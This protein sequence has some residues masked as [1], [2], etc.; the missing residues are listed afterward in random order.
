MNASGAL[1]ITT[2]SSSNLSLNSNA[3]LTS[4]ATGN[5]ISLIS[6]GNLTLESG[7][8]ISAAGPVL[9]AGN[10][11][12]NNAGS[13]AVTAS[14][15][16]WLIYSNNPG[17]D[18][19]G[20]LNSGNNA[21]WDASYGALPPGNVTAGSNRYLFA[22]QPTLTFTTTGASKTY[23]Q[24]VTSSIANNFS[25]SGY[26]S[27]I[28]N[29][30][31][32]DAAGSTFSGIP[33]VT[34]NGA[35]ASASV[36]GS[37]YAISIAQ[38]TVAALSGY[39]LTFNSA[40][41]L[42]VNPAQVTV[43]ALGGSSTYGASPSNPGLSAT[44]LQNGQGV[45]VLT[46][47]SNSF[48]IT[49]TSNAGNYTLNVAGTLSDANYTVA[50]AN[51]G[52]WTVDPAQVIVTALG[53]S[54]T[55]GAPSSNPGLS[56]TGMQNG[57][58]VGVLD[59]AVELVRN[60]CDVARR[61]SLTERHRYTQQFELRSGRNKKRSLERYCG[62]YPAFSVSTSLALLAYRSELLAEYFGAK[63]L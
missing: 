10:A 23:G 8:S 47:L 41:T 21:I 35:V 29:V 46:G 24:D 58:N 42:A 33:S 60:H 28:A 43:T 53:G 4:S 16:R 51:T 37:L 9:A 15:G 44:G 54:S 63:Q 22:Y 39:A 30:F 27:G 25:V 6:A 17:S 38:G 61:Q 34:S 12:V 11:F 19:F 45:R 50:T 13:T 2:L 26:Q 32:G 14:S 59:R 3:A 62:C 31:S 7:S 57:Q 18:T 20:G 5:A 52:N 1:T 40:S 55:Y 49:N 56:A 36:A 48:G